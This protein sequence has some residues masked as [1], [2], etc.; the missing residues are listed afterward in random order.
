MRIDRAQLTTGNFNRNAIA[1]LRPGITIGAAEAEM[2][3][4][5]MRLPDDVPGMMTRAIF[6][7]AKI[8]VVIH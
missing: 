1:R 8:R 6:D 5:L 3:P 2:Q 7:Q 4:I